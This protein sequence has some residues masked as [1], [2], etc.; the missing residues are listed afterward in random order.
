MEPLDQF[1]GRLR[2]ACIALVVIG[3]GFVWF[4]LTI[5]AQPTGAANYP[6]YNFTNITTNTTTQVLTGDGVLHT[7]CINNAGAASNTAS[8]YDDDDGTS[9]PIGVIDTV[10]LNGRCFL[11]DAAVTTGIRV[12]T[13]TGTAADLTVTYRALR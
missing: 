11:Y 4:D 5:A 10:E 1:F 6:V 12:I 2:L 3:L 13:G 7:V 9:L 8:I